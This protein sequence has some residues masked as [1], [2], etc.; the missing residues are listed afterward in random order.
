LNA[1]DVDGLVVLHSSEKRY[2]PGETA[3]CRII[4]VNNVDLEAVPV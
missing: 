1:P 2:K 3:E 4:K